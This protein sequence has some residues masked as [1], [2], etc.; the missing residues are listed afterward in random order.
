MLIA[1]AGTNNIKNG[2][3]ECTPDEVCV[4]AIGVRE[5]ISS[6]IWR[7]PLS[8]NLVKRKCV[9][10]KNYADPAGPQQPEA[11]GLRLP[12]FLALSLASVA[13]LKPAG[14]SRVAAATA[15]LA[16]SLTAPFS[17]V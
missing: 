15:F 5:R 1:S 13:E 6:L 2:V 8:N 4:L 12:L 7:E 3:T 14:Q 9:F 16:L 17:A 11:V 10:N